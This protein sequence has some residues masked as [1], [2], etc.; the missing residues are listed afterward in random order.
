VIALILIAMAVRVVKQYERGVP[1]RFGRLIRVPRSAEDVSTNGAA[2][3]PASTVR[4]GR[5][6]LDR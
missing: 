5:V 2:A 4:D 1:F 6:T 3:V